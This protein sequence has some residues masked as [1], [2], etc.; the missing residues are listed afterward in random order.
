MTHGTGHADGQ[1]SVASLTTW[2][3][4]TDTVMSPATTAARRA[5]TAAFTAFTSTAFLPEGEVV[6]GVAIF[7]APR[8]ATVFNP[9]APSCLTSSLYR[10]ACFSKCARCR[11]DDRRQ[12][13][14]IVQRRRYYQDRLRTTIRKLNF[15]QLC[16]Q[17][18]VRRAERLWERSEWWSGLRH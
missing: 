17:V 2:I 13:L 18:V 5:A 16:K 15:R 11:D 9:R 10:V 6:L 3:T 4:R 12:G 1:N 7:A 8:A 14:S